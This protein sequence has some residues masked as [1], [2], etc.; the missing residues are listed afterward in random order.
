MN[1]LVEQIGMHI[2]LSFMNSIIPDLFSYKKRKE[3]RNWS[4]S[5]VALICATVSWPVVMKE[6]FDQLFLH[7]MSI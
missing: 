7:G 2:F 4:Q 6:E 3:K 5:H 1:E